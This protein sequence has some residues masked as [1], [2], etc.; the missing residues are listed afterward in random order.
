MK[1]KI[2][3]WPCACLSLLGINIIPLSLTSC[4]NT[5]AE[6]RTFNLVKNYYPTVKKHDTEPLSLHNTNELYAQ[7]LNDLITETFLT[8]IKET[9]DYINKLVND[10]SKK[11]LQT[12][13]TLLDKIDTSLTPD[14]AKDL[15]NKTKELSGN[16][17]PDLF[18]PIR[19][20]TTGI[21]H[22]PELNKVLAIL[23]KGLIKTRIA[24]VLLY[25]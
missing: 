5:K 21:E 9:P 1:T 17:G 15:I 14:M 6:G 2:R 16:K 8:P 13:S 10:V 25:K 19:L 12:F 22:G 7:Q 24:K 4:A 11:T 3:L 18:M 20:A 23:G